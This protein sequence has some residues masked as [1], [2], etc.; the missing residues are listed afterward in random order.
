M[1]CFFATSLASCAWLREPTFKTAH[2]LESRWARCRRSNTTGVVF[3]PVIAV[4][5][6]WQ[7]MFSR[8]PRWHDRKVV[9]L[10]L[11]A[12]AADCLLVIAAAYRFQGLF[13]PWGSYAFQSVDLK[14]VQQ[15]TAS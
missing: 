10:Q 12:M 3:F 8:D 2:I 11:G 5:A 14:T 13:E 4:L 7:L 15:L 9:L 6:V 1:A